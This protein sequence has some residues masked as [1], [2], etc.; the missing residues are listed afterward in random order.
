MHKD[1][2]YQKHAVIDQDLL[3]ARIR[4]STMTVEP[5]VM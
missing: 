5:K 2:K 1:L 4:V 3:K